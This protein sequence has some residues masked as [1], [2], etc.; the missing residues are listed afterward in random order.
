MHLSQ[1]RVERDIREG[2]VAVVSKKRLGVPSVLPHPRAAQHQNVGIA[3]VVIVRLDHVETAEDSRESGLRGSIAEGSVL[4]VQEQP[5]LPRGIVGRDQK[6]QIA[7]VVEVLG[8]RAPREAERIDARAPRDVGKP[9]ERFVGSKGL[10]RNPVS[11]RNSLGVLADGHVS[12][13]EEPERGEVSGRVLLHPGQNFLEVFDRSPGAFRKKVHSVAANGKNAAIGIVSKSAVLG[14]SEAQVSEA[15]IEDDSRHDA[16]VELVLHLRKELVGASEVIDGFPLT[17]EPLLRFSEL[18][19]ELES[20]EVGCI[21]SQVQRA[22]PELAGLSIV[23]PVVLHR[24]A[25]SNVREKLEHL[26]MSRSL[27]VEGRLRGDLSV[28]V[29]WR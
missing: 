13:V 24:R 19:V 2:P 16:L 26:S 10:G 9:R 18:Q 1:P 17:P 22:G 7:V 23:E 27:L 21:G 29:L 15:E 28:R 4:L 8:H 14:F 6:V 12:D 11:R 3:V 5:Q 25:V 20:A